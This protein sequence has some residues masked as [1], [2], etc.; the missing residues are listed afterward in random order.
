MKLLL[1]NGMVLWVKEAKQIVEDG[2]CL[3]LTTMRGRG[4][5]YIASQQVAAYWW[6]NENVEVVRLATEVHDGK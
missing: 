4:L 2:N 5:A 6:D 3:I 1:N